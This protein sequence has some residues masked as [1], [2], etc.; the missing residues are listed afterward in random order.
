MGIGFASLTKNG[1]GRGGALSVDSDHI[2]TG[3]TNTIAESH[4]DSYFR[5]TPAELKEGVSIVIESAENNYPILQEY[6][7]GS[8][9]DLT[10]VIQGRS[11]A[12]GKAAVPSPV[13]KAIAQSMAVYSKNGKPNLDNVKASW[14]FIHTDAVSDED[15]KLP[16]G[17]AIGSIVK[18]IGDQKTGV[19]VTVGMSNDTNGIE[20]ESGTVE[21][22]ISL[23][24]LERLYLIKAADRWTVFDKIPAIF[25]KSELDDF[26]VLTLEPLLNSGLNPIKQEQGVLRQQMIT[27]QE[28]IAA[29]SKEH[30]GTIVPPSAEVNKVYIGEGS[31]FPADLS[32]ATDS[33]DNLT[34]HLV[35][36]GLDANPSKVWIAITKVHENHVVGIVE[37]SGLGS[38]WASQEITDKGETWVVYLSPYEFT[39]KTLSLQIQWG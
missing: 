10:T 16:E 9:V 24:R 29:L 20:V 15:I 31:D 33:E 30:P 1:S 38:T 37:G 23:A 32:G 13:P 19:V 8:W 25:T 27:M 4:R 12:P 6:R 14:Y 26:S 18:V 35:W 28:Q 21:D 39:N 34:S 22:D 3:A 5:G 36:T 2:F 7:K 17:A 11:G